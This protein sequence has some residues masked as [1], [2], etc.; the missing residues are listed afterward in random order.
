[1]AEICQV[2]KH[3]GLADNIAFLKSI[4]LDDK[5]DTTII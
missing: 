5:R 2:V 4:S 1:M 3:M